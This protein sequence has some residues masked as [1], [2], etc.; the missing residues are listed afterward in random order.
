MIRQ[1]RN[2]GLSW[3]SIARGLGVSRTAALARGQHLGLGPP[4]Q[5]RDI[6]CLASSRGA[7]A[8]SA[9]PSGPARL[10]L[11][12]GHEVSWGAITAGTALDG[13]SYPEVSL[14][15]VAGARL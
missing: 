13:I 1:S 4:C 11:P 12:P 7:R 14:D 8:P 10:P 2:R 5:P 9:A 15:T 3:A 6:T